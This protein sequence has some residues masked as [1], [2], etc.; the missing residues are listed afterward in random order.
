VSALGLT[1]PLC[2]NQIDV[3]EPAIGITP[4]VSVLSMLQEPTIRDQRTLMHLECFR[5]GG[6]SM[7][8]FPAQYPNS[9]N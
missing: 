3:R 7:L 6:A 2:S 1:C 4:V 8:F 9:Q 5:T